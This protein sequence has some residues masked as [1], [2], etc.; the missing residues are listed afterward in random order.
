[1]VRMPTTTPASDEPN[2][3]ST[4]HARWVE[5]R[6]W[7]REKLGGSILEFRPVDQDAS[8][9]RYFRVLT[10]EGSVILM[11]APPQHENSA[12]FLDI[13]SR[14]RKGGLHA[15]QVFHFDLERGFGLLEDLGDR[16]YRDLLDPVSA[17]ALF[18][19]LFETLAR[20]AHRVESRELPDYDPMRLQMELDLFVDW[21]LL[22]HRQQHLRV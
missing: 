1:M 3:E 20:M 16:L 2:Q 18:P 4:D 10:S 21:Y 15:P 12:P 22:R 14:L 5:A 13:A 6:A 11:D 17:D 8:F 7:A 9:R 19:G